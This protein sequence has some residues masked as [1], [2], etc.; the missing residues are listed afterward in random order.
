VSAAPGSITPGQTAPDPPAAQSIVVTKVH[1]AASRGDGRWVYLD[2]FPEA[3]G[4]AFIAEEGASPLAEIS[5]ALRHA[6][7]STWLNAGVAPPQVA[8]W[9]GHS[10]DILLRVCA[11][12][13]HGQ[14]DRAKRRILQATQPDQASEQ[15]PRWLPR[16]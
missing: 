12:C 5:Y 1:P 2:V 13:I 14:Q 15:S 11:K 10:V 8:E 16:R 4:L 9:A 7:V 6:A 3:R